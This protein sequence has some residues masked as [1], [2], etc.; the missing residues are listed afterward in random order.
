MLNYP[1][2]TWKSL[3]EL[4]AGELTSNLPFSFLLEITYGR[5]MRCD[6][7]RGKQFIIVWISPIVKIGILHHRKL[8]SDLIW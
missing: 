8:R 4:D 1:Q 6:D 5:C 2:L 7:I 3:D